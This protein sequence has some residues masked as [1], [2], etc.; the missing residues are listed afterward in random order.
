MID[1]NLFTDDAKFVISLTEKSFQEAIIPA[2]KI[3][4]EI[5]LVNF[6]SGSCGHCKELIVD[7]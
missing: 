4:T 7:W 1:G 6:Y 3:S 2:F 5:A